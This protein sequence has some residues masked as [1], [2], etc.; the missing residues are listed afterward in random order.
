MS[1]FLD[2]LIVLVSINYVYDICVNQ[3]EIFNS[4]SFCSYYK[5]SQY[6]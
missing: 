1:L 4:K 5:Q 2:N 6:C 3:V